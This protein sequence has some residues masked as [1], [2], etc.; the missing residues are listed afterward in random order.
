MLRLIQSSHSLSRFYMMAVA[1]NGRFLST[2]S[3]KVDEP[4][5]VEEGE[6]V[7]SPPPPL[8]KLLVLGGN[9]FVGSHVCKE[10]L[11]R[12]L[13]VASLSWYHLPQ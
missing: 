7:N 4:F 9:G 13:S 10:A 12:G 5:K 2:D 1:S 8:E 11:D 3:T 6:T